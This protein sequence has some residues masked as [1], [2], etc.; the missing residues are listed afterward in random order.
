MAGSLG[1]LALVGAGGFVGSIMRYALS[2]VVHR[3]VPMA[4][5][6][7]GTLAVN[8]LGCLLIGVL[9]GLSD[10]RNVFGRLATNLPIVVEIVDTREKIDAFLP[11]IE[12]IEVH[13]YRGGKD[14][15]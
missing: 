1:T 6:P 15:S 2:G 9:V 11:V 4:V 12:K 10:S 14:S 3:F 8:G 7:Y 5:F 13:W